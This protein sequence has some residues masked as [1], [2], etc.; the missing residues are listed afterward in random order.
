MILPEY[1]PLWSPEV[2]ARVQ[3]LR[4]AD[5]QLSDLPKHIEF[6]KRC[7]VSNQ[8]PRIVFKDGVCSACYHKDRDLTRDWASRGNEFVALLEK[9]RRKGGYDVIVPTSGGKDSGPIAHRLKTDW[10]MN[11]LAV[12]WAPFG[13][14]DIGFKNFQSF[15][16]S[17]FDCLTCFP[18]GF[19]LRKLARI[20]LEV[21]GDAWQPFAYGQMFYA[22]HM[23]HRFNIPL[24]FFGENGEAEYGGDPGADDK[25]CWGFDDWERVYYKGAGVNKLVDIGIECGAFTEDERRYVSEF[26]TLPPMDFLKQ[27]E[28]HWWSYYNFWHP[29]SNYYHA[30]EHLNFE[31]NPEGRSEGTYS[32]Y[33]SLDDRMDGFHY[34]LAFIKFGIGRCT[35]DAAH[36][37]RDGDITREEGVARVYRFDGE[38][39]ARHYPE[40]MA[41]HGLTDEHFQAVCDRWRRPE[42]WDGKTLRHRVA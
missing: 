32:R 13:Y 25:R 14:T 2:E 24:I 11:P 26:Y 1:P 7:V 23:S 16:H 41:Y 21:L 20:A 8:R 19:I 18:N 34:Y 35:S 10:R 31:G 33:A 36:E 5:P 42:I 40:F 38:F 6:C 27:T 12:K 3:E 15:I 4:P 37:I 17:G 39:P 28:V 9:H 30:A 22:L 29:Q